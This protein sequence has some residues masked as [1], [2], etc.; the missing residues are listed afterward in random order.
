MVETRECLCHPSLATLLHWW[1]FFPMY[2]LHRDKYRCAARS[3]L[4]LQWRALVRE[5]QSHAL[6]ISLRTHRSLLF[7]C[8]GEKE[9]YSRAGVSTP[10]VLPTVSPTFYLRAVDEISTVTLTMHL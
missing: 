5:N 7:F 1:N 10:F 9:A 8:G 2:G 4:L 3:R 6:M